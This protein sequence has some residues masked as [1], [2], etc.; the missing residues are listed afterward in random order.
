MKSKSKNKPGG[1]SLYP[2]NKWMQQKSINLTRGKHYKCSTSTMIQQIRN[3][4]C[5][6]GVSA[7]IDETDRGIKVFLEVTNRTLHEAVVEK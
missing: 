2:W 3:R 1:V 6:Y 5:E 7:S 4:A